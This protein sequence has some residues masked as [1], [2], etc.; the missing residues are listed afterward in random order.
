MVQIST[1]FV[2]FTALCTAATS[3]SLRLPF[4]PPME[5][6]LERRQGFTIPP[7]T[8]AQLL[9]GYNATCVKV[10]SAEGAQA[11]QDDIGNITANSLAIQVRTF[12]VNAIA[13]CTF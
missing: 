2:L 7:I 10:N 3:W 4:S 13:V 11:I 5:S 1:S 6:N 12:F 8:P 9:M